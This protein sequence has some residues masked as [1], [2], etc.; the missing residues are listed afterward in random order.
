MIW[1]ISGPSNAG[2]STFIRSP[3]C[4]ALT[5]LPADAPVFF[6]I[7][8]TRLSGGIDRDCFFHYNILRPADLERRAPS[9]GAPSASTADAIDFAQ[10][11]QWREVTSLPA[12]KAAIV[13]VVDAH[14]LAAR[15][16]RRRAV[17]DSPGVHTTAPIYPR[18]RWLALYGTVNFLELY[19]AWCAELDGHRIGYRLLDARTEP[20]SDMA[21][22]AL[23]AVLGLE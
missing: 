16:I 5:G 17:E 2:K 9:R 20:C 12:A 6:P 1:I 22:A 10:D 19:R 23:P 11:P 4:S 15:A 8:S 3:Q 21:P 14:T 7:G 18:E 13:L